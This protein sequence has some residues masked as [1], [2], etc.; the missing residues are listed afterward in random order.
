MKFANP[1]G[2]I[3]AGTKQDQDLTIVISPEGMQ[4]FPLLGHF[5]ERLAAR[6]KQLR[7]KYGEDR[8]KVNRFVGDF[9]YKQP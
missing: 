2:T 4:V 3:R 6:I 1:Y 9:R 7:E 5:D 8:V